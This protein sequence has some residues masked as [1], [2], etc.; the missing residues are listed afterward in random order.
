M[1]TVIKYDPATDQDQG[2]D[3][4]RGGRAACAA[5]WPATSTGSA[6]ST[7]A[8]ASWWPTSSSPPTGHVAVETLVQEVAPGRAAGQRGHRLPDHEAPGRVRA[9]RA[10]AVRRHP[11]PLRAGRRPPAPRPP[12]LHRL[13]RHRGVRQRAHRGA[14]GARW[15]RATA[16]R[17][18]PTPWSSTAAA[19]PAGGAP[20]WWRPARERPARLPAPPAVEAAPG[21]RRAAPGGRSVILVGN[22]NVG[23]SVLFG[24]LTGR[25]VTVSNYPGTT[26]EVTRGHATIEGEPWHVMDTPGTNNLLP[27]SEDEQVTRDILLAEPGSTC[28]QVCDAKNLRRGPPAHRPA[29]RGRGPL[30]AGAQHGRRGQEPRLRHRPRG[31]S[32]EGAGHRGGADGGGAAPGAGHAAGRPRQAPGRPRFVPRYDVQIEAGAR[33]G[34]AAH[35]EGRP[36]ARARWRS[37]RWPATTRC[38]AWLLARMAPAGAGPA[39]RGAARAGR[40]LPRVAPLR[41]GPAAA[42]GGGPAPRRGG[43]RRGA[44]RWRAAWRR[45]LGA[46]STH[47]LYGVPV[48]LP[49]ALRLLRVRGRLRG[50]RPRRLPRAHGLP[51]PHRAL[52]RGGCSGRCSRPAPVQEFLVGPAGVP[53]TRSTA[54]SSSGATAWSPWGSPTRWPSCCP[55]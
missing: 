23:K 32:A 21:Q 46:W 40:P 34:G 17:S 20:G 16:S 22:P 18:R 38:H 28:L 13:R 52:G 26:V 43:P 54:A 15:P 10:A 53:W 5:C 11:D 33:R 7:R 47:P 30:P 39:R 27:M 35:A 3:G 25:Y 44:A 49:G 50:R 55:S 6:S 2:A 48:L 4:G 19:P 41:G 45:R 31:R 36:G 9:G 42:G 8:S 37:W 1:R 24:A 51:R 12:H 29:R 14:P